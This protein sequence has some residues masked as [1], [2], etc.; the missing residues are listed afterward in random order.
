MKIV[1]F[2]KVLKE[3]DL[4]IKTMRKEIETNKLRLDDLEKTI[5]SKD[6]IVQDIIE[7][8]KNMVKQ[9]KLETEISN[10]HENTIKCVMVIATKVDNTMCDSNEFEKEIMEFYG[11]NAEY[12][13]LEES[14][15]LENTFANP[16]AGFKCEICDLIAK[17]ESGLK[18]HKK[19]KHKQK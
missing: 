8:M 19:K 3:K 9:E 11:D 10:L 1:G 17:S 5:V 13:E 14:D 12:E 16:S 2:E 18:I 4:E 6:S 15:L 7:K